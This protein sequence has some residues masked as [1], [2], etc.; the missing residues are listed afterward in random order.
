[1]ADEEKL[2]G[3]RVDIQ[4]YVDH[5]EWDGEQF[6]H[7]ERSCSQSFMSISPVK[8][9]GYSDIS[10][11]LEFAPGTVVYVV[12]A[13]YSSGD[14]FGSDYRCHSQPVGV[15]SNLETAKK[16]QEHA[17]KETNYTADLYIDDERVYYYAAWVGYFEE[18]NEMHIE[19][20]V[21][22]A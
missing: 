2:Y 4:E 13:E 15:F 7:W 3:Y 21:M 19:T 1:M 12:W 10:S 18:L 16:V 14:S 11:N 17:S 6:G 9:A 8:K 20:T 5:D 22:G